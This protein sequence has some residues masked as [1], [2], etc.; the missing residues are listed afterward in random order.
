MAKVKRSCFVCLRRDTESDPLILKGA[1]YIC[2]T[3]EPA[4][5]EYYK[6]AMGIVD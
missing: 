1:K 6:N 3:C 5:D 4:W 2:S